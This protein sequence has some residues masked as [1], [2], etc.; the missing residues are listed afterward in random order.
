[1]LLSPNLSNIGNP[2]IFASKLLKSD[3]VLSEIIAQV[4]SILPQLANF[5]G[6]FNTTVSQSGIN[7]IT[8]TMGS[9]SI[10]VPQ[11]MSEEAANK[12]SIRI[13][14]IDNLI[15]AKSQTV[16]DLLQKGTVLENKLKVLDSQYVSQLTDRMQEYKRLISSYNH[17]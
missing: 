17:S 7:V 14:V 11:G 4:D 9:M 13:G 5:I 16:N 1:V 15:A 12:L 2:P 8:D 6:Q 3:L 10:D